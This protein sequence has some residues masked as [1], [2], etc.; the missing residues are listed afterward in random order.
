MISQWASYVTL[1]FCKSFKLTWLWWPF[2]NSLLACLSITIKPLKWYWTN[3]RN[4]LCMPSITMN[5]V[6][7]QYG[8]HKSSEHLT[9]LS[10]LHFSQSKS[11]ISDF[12]SQ[13]NP[14]IWFAVGPA[15]PASLH[16]AGRSLT[17]TAMT[18]RESLPAVCFI[19]L[20]NQVP[21][22]QDGKKK[23]TTSRRKWFISSR[24][25]SLGPGMILTRYIFFALYHRLGG[26]FRSPI[27]TDPTN[28][29]LPEILFLYGLNQSTERLHLT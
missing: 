12:M 16:A 24:D 21:S 2:L 20:V 10:H 13:H 28:F 5:L 22:F 29:L 25:G 8:S 27:A 6:G 7:S 26:R 15:R 18:D 23:S 1:P 4:R 11:T 17:A 3:P 9:P 19:V 14:H